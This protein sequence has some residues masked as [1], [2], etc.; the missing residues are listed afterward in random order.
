MGDHVRFAAITTL[1]VSSIEFCQC[2]FDEGKIGIRLGGGGGHGA[3]RRLRQMI[4]PLAVRP[5]LSYGF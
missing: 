2:T 5:E 3:M 1:A 4:F